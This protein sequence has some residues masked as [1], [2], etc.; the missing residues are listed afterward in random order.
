MSSVLR[1]RAAYM[2]SVA[3]VDE[4]IDSV[5]DTLDALDVTDQTFVL[6]TADHGDQ[7]GDHYLWRK[8]FPYEGSA[9]VPLIV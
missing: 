4:Q 2:A 8:G 3:F 6:F 1:S 5:L 7:L 9:H